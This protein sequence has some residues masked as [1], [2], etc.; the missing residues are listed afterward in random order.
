MNHSILHERHLMGLGLLRDFG[1]EG[2]LLV[3][4][5]LIPEG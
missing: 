4:V 2:L 3:I 1:R 5:E